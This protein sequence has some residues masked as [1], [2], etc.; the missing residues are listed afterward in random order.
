M[1]ENMPC[2][3]ALG[4]RLNSEGQRTGLRGNGAEEKK[5]E[6]K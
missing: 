2:S 6:K 4:R 5:K 3:A 1:L